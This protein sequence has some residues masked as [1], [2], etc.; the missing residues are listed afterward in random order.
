MSKLLSNL[1]K[2]AIGVG[3]VY[4]AYKVGESMGKDEKMNLL[5]SAK[6]ELDYEIEF[7]TNM[8]KSY[9]DKP[10]KTKEDEENLYLF[11]L[12]LDNLQKK[13]DNN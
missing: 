4:T 13:Y 3:V 11:K 2:T 6:S 9:T 5:K 12:K 8:I 7:V 10:K 1:L